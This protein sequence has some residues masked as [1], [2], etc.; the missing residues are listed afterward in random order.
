LNH[1]EFWQ[2]M[3]EKLV[4]PK[5]HLPRRGPHWMVMALW[6]VAGLV[7][8][9]IAVFAVIAW[10]HQG[11]QAAAVTDP[12]ASAPASAPAAQVVPAAPPPAAEAVPAASRPTMTGGMPPPT[13]LASRKTAIRHRARSHG[14]ARGAKATARTGVAKPEGESKSDELDD[15]LR[16][17]K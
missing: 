11:G 4:L 14:P 10:R 12:A 1:E 9:Q 5:F 3:S 8:I 15:L 13:A 16:K 6:G 7:V 2:K 17:F